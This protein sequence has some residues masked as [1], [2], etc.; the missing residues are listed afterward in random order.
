MDKRNQGLTRISK[1]EVLINEVLYTNRD[2][3]WKHEMYGE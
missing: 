1:L 2:A 3:C